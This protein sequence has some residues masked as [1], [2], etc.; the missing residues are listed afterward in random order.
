MADDMIFKPGTYVTMWTDGLAADTIDLKGGNRD[1]V[2]KELTEWYRDT[3]IFHNVKYDDGD[4]CME[5]LGGDWHEL[6]A[7]DLEL[8]CIGYDYAT[9]PILALTVNLVGDVWNRHID[10]INVEDL[11]CLS[12]ERLYDVV[13]EYERKYCEYFHENGSGGCCVLP[14]TSVDDVAQHMRDN[15]SSE[16]LE[17][18]ITR[19][20]EYAYLF[21]HLGTEIARAAHA[22]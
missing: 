15:L 12:I 20:H 5:R 8:E 16:C 6:M 4:K 21:Q 11:G 1:E 17:Q 10:L 14:V 3:A 13:K 19:Y 18:F 22:L 7:Y 2:L 9:E